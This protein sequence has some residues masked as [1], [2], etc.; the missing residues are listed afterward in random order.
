MRGPLYYFL[1]HNG[2]KLLKILDRLEVCGSC[3]HCSCKCQLRGIYTTTELG[4]NCS[5]YKRRRN[6][7]DCIDD[8]DSEGKSNE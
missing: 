1:T 2:R 3:T 8:L 7:K 6:V 5:G 4:N